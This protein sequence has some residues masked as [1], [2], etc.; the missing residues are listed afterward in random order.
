VVSKPKT[1]IVPVAVEW[2]ME[3]EAHNAEEAI[4]EAWA[5]MVRIVSFGANAGRKAVVKGSKTKVKQ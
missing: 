3:V 5:R 1:Y 2:K 4:R